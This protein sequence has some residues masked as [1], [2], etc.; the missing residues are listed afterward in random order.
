MEPH[1]PVFQPAIG[2]DTLKAVTDAFNVGWLGM[3]AI[4]KEFEERIA[5][6]LGLKDRFVVATN[7]GTSAL[8]IGLLVAG[9][10]PGDEVITPAHNFVADH[11]AIIATGAEPVLCDVR[12][13]DLG[14]DCDKAEKLISPS[15]KAIIPLHYAGIPC[16]V[17]EAYALARKYKLRVVEDATHAFG[18]TVAGKPIGSFGDISCFSFD[19]VKIITSIDGGAVVT[20]HA[21]DVQKLHQ[22]RLLGIDKETTERYK[23]SRAWEYDV[24]STGFRYHLTNIMASIGIS[25]IQRVE[26]F[27]AN[28]RKYCRLYSKLLSDVPQV[29]TP[30]SDFANVSPF[31]Y[32]IRVPAAQRSQLIGHL[33]AKGI[34]TG[35]HFVP[36]HRFTF[37]KQFRAGDMTVTERIADELVTLPLHSVMTS[38]TIERITGEVVRFFDVAKSTDRTVERNAAVVIGILDRFKHEGRVLTL[39]HSGRTVVRLRAV[40]HVNNDLLEKDILLLAKWRNAHRESFMTWFIATPEG[41]RDWVMRE[42][43]IGKPRILFIVESGGGQAMGHMGLCSFDFVARSAEADNILRGEGEVPGGMTSALRGLCSWAFDT[44]DMRRVYLRVFADNVPAV[45]LYQRCGF[46][47]FKRT[48]VRRV[49]DGEVTRWVEAREGGEEPQQRYLSWM[50]LLR[51]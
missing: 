13:D 30:A 28:R 38:E 5:A 3:G 17:D 46:K 16:R 41:T 40:S 22:Y 9:V 49:L 31:I 43:A 36:A 35:I 45:A 4:T 42:L 48:P 39:A 34:A 27:I 18:T 26:E 20:P 10:G 44:L 24:V 1:I 29:R 47:E 37:I 19:P 15:T 2:I 50:E 6:F 12:D 25:Q 51:R 14:I 32:Y 8:H 7:T 11:Q 21:G 23:N 33:K